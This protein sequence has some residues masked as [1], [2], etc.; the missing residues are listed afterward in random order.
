MRTG[1]GKKEGVK[2]GEKAKGFLLWYPSVGYEIHT[3]QHLVSSKEGYLALEG[4]MKDM[5]LEMMPPVEVTSPLT[6]L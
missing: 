5:T 4:L 1:A 6:P 3:S 2:K